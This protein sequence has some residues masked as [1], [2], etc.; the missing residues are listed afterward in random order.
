MYA[1]KKK[2]IWDEVFVTHNMDENQALYDGTIR[3]MILRAYSYPIT[4]PVQP[5][6]VLE[7]D[8]KG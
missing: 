4:V 5:I 7:E 1:E 3:G 6:L 2:G 8:E